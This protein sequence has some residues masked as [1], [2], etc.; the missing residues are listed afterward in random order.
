MDVLLVST[1][2]ALN[3]GTWA[4]PPLLSSRL[5]LTSISFFR[6]V[7]PGIVARLKVTPPCPAV[8]HDLGRADEF[9]RES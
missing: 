6:L 9:P 8:N 1:A 2:L 4:G 5:H 7:P 3:L